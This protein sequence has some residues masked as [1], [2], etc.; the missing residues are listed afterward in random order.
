MVGRANQTVDS[1][2]SRVTQ[3]EWVIRE[4]QYE[5]KNS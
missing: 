1:L 4:L 2:Q 3:L 5:E